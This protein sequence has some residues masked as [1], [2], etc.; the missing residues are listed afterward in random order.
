MYKK[1]KLKIAVSLYILIFVCLY[2]YSQDKDTRYLKGFCQVFK[3]KNY[4]IDSV[5]DMKYSF[6]VCDSKGIVLNKIANSTTTFT[7]K[8]GAGGYWGA[9]NKTNGNDF[10]LIIIEQDDNKGIFIFDIIMRYKKQIYQAK[11]KKLVPFNGKKTE[12]FSFNMND[13]VK[14]PKLLKKLAQHFTKQYNRSMNPPFPYD[15]PPRKC[16]NIVSEELID[17]HSNDPVDI[18]NRAKLFAKLRPVRKEKLAPLFKKD[19]LKKYWRDEAKGLNIKDSTNIERIKRG[20]KPILFLSL[21][22]TA[23][24]VIPERGTVE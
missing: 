1:S 21:K 4:A 2:S 20:L 17:I 24:E 6:A 15:T 14:D 23:W 22:P 13:Y 11:L 16:L 12:I 3:T 19:S 7:P 5:L 18:R 10:S 9:R 8:K